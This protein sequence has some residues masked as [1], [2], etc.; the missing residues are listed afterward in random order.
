MAAIFIKSR[1][2]QSVKILNQPGT[3][4]DLELWEALKARLA[5]TDQQLADILNNT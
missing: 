1:N 5:V 3:T 4:Y 2:D